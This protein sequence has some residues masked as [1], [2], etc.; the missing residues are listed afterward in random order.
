MGVLGLSIENLLIQHVDL[1]FDLFAEDFDS[2]FG[3]D[4]LHNSQEREEIF[5][6]LRVP[7]LEDVVDPLHEVG[8]LDVR[9][10]EKPNHDFGFE[11]LESLIKFV[12]I[13]FVK[14]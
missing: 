10:L 13:I 7:V 11:K 8:Q 1:L 14:N 9:L 6:L 4:A 12:D 3:N 2:Q 5:S